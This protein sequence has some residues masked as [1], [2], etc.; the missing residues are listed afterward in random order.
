MQGNAPRVA[1][2][3]TKQASV[4]VSTV[5]LTNAFHS[6]LKEVV[7]PRQKIKTCIVL[8]A[9]RYREEDLII[10]LNTLTT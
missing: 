9:D 10:L 3:L 2:L 4:V 6:Y 8:E 7:V 5:S 1:H